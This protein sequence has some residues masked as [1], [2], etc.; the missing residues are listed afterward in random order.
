MISRTTL[1]LLFPAYLAAALP[2]NRNSSLTWAPCDINFP[3]SLESAITTPIECANLAVPLDY[4][5][6]KF[7]KTVQLQLVRIPATQQPAK[8]SIIFNPGG[9]GGSGVQEV[10]T[11]GQKYL[12]VFKGQYNIVGFDTRG[13]GRTIPYTCGI[14]GGSTDGP[15][16]KRRANITTLPQQSGDDVF[17]FLKS[18]SWDDNRIFAD[19][20]EKSHADIGRFVNTAFIARDL[21]AIVD[22]LGEDGLLRFWG[23]SYS[24]VLGQTFAAMFPDRVGRLL[25]DSVVKA[26]DYN[27]GSWQSA[28]HDTDKALLNFFSECIKSGPTNCPL[29]NFSGPATTPADLMNGLSNIFQELIENPIILPDAYPIVPPWWQP[30]GIPLYHEIKYTIFTQLYKPSNFGALI[31]ILGDVYRKN[32][33]AWTN[34][35][36]ADLPSGPAPETWNPQQSIALFG[37]ACSDSTFRAKK[38]E[39]MYNLIQAQAGQGV[40]ADASTSTQFWTCAQWPFHAAERYEGNYRDIC[41]KN[42]ILLANNVFDPV[43]PLTRA[44]DVAFGFKGSR[45]LVQNGHGH[46]IMNHPS[47]CTM[48]AINNYFDSGVLPDHGTV[49]EPNQSAYEVALEAA[50]A[51]LAAQNATGGI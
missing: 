3:E 12:D 37:I 14:A 39:D 27:D 1:S 7:G 17:E 9:P 23:R 29:A 5:N 51:A 33:S 41:T 50:Q 8:G 22:A 25:L 49:C 21:L 36:A 20:C 2:S 40:F 28:I 24:T 13:V 15:D 42:P 19:K 43:T 34:L 6:P 32:W 35:T 45:M 18:K 38:P 16:L 47:N 46:G 10:S 31:T 4:T 30:G 44:W 11:E 26:S 48:E